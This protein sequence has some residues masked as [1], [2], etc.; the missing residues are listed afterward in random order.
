VTATETVT[1]EPTGQPATTPGTIEPTPSDDLRPQIFPEVD[2]GTPGAV[3]LGFFSILLISTL[4]LIGMYAG[5]YLGYKDG[6]K[7][8]AKFLRA[9]LGK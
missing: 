9:L 2:L 3:G 7:E 6:D 5:Y 1:A 8:E 4:I